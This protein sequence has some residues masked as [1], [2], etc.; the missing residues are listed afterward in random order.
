[1]QQQCHTRRK[2]IGL[3]L[4]K[5][6]TAIDSAVNFYTNDAAGMQQVAAALSASA[7]AAAAA[8]RARAAQGAADA[9]AAAAE[10][11]DGGGSSSGGGGGGG[12][13]GAGPDGSGQQECSGHLSTPKPRLQLGK[14]L[15]YKVD[16]EL[17]RRERWDEGL[18]LEQLQVGRA[19]A[20]GAVLPSCVG[21]LA[22]VRYALASCLLRTPWTNLCNGMMVV[23]TARVVVAVC[24]SLGAQAACAKHKKVFSNVVTA[25]QYEAAKSWLGNRR[26]FRFEGCKETASIGVLNRRLNVKYDVSLDLSRCAM[27]G[28]AH[29][30]QVASC[31]RYA[32]VGAGVRGRG[33]GTACLCPPHAR[34]TSTPFPR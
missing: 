15:H 1:M 20:L 11:R 6:P 31:K 3:S 30:G 9:D 13:R 8:A 16:E 27:H 18:G 12:P 5:H 14:Q 23:C 28:R 32:Y 34:G 19:G 24:C 21:S 25:S 7:H 4:Q 2:T 10:A 22:R 26:G 33:G 17:W 29:T